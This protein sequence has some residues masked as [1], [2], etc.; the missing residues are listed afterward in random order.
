MSILPPSTIGILGSGQLGRMLA[1]VARRMGYRVHVY[2]PGP[3]SPAGQLADVSWTSPYEDLEQVRAFAQ[4]VDV[5][6]Y[7]FENIPLLTAEAVSEICPLRPGITALQVA[8]NRQRE[9]SFLQE[10]GLPVSPFRIINSESDFAP[11]DWPLPAVLKTA[12]SGYDGKGQVVIREHGAAASAWEAIGRQSAVLESFIDLEKEIS[13]IIGRDVQGNM[14]TYGPIENNHVNHILDLSLCPA[15]VDPNITKMALINAHTIATSLDLIGVICVEFFIAS[16]GQL[17]V[18]E[19]APRPH[20]SGHLTIE[21]HVTSQFE[22]QLRT[23][24]GLPVGDASQQRPAAMANLLGDLWLEGEPKWHRATPNG[25]VKVHLYGKKE[26]RPGRKMGHL[27][28]CT[29]EVRAAREIVLAA[30]ERLKLAR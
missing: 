6:T 12:E 8:Q 14:V 22:Q 10:N 24:C 26:A 27:T 9:K 28:V 30:R 29:E 1:S 17:L 13:V 4:A 7:E 2:G 3:D 18:N 21:G 25:M 19:I 16:N 5:V 20:N 11:F 15:E 23:I